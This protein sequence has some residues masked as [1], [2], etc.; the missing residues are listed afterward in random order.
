MPWVAAVRT[1]D[2]AHVFTVAEDGTLLTSHANPSAPQWRPLEVHAERVVH[3]Y[4]ELTAT[5]RGGSNVDVFFIG[6][7]RALHT[8]W[9]NPA[10]TWPARTDYAIG[11]TEA[12]MPTSAL[13]AVS[14]S[15]NEV[16][17]FGVGFDLRLHVASWTPG[18]WLAPAAVGAPNE[19]LAAHTRV[20]AAWNPV[21][22]VCEVLAVAN[23]LQLCLYSVGRTG[24]S[25]AGTGPRVAIMSPA[26]DPRTRVAPSAPNPFGDLCLRMVGG[27]RVAIA[28]FAEANGSVAR[29]AT[30][31][32]GADPVAHN[33]TNWQPL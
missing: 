1:G 33:W 14:P 29:V 16:I 31:P 13:A 19:L 10:R 3:Q 5:V 7:D 9:W 20:A 12:L 8:A 22:S 32:L 23:D 11:P 26:P 15:A 28:L 6:A 2:D 25:W 18:A 4:S 24:R 17:V 21:T 30:C 27:L